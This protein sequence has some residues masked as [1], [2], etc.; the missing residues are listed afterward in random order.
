MKN[1]L[2][3]LMLFMPWI[4]VA[5]S[6]EKSRW[7]WGF[8]SGID[9]QTMG[10]ETFGQPDLEEPHVW[11]EGPRLGLSGGVLVK[12]TVL[13]WLEFLPGFGLSMINNFVQ[14]RPDGARAYRFYDMEIPLYFQ[15]IDA[16]KVDAPVKGCILAG[17]RFSWNLADNASDFLKINR[18]RFAA[19]LGLGVQLR[20][21]NWHIQPVF[22]Y[23]HGF[24]DLHF[25][26]QGKYDDLVGRVVRDKF[27]LKIQC[28]KIGK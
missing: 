1:C 6:N 16:R 26:D 19:D 14:Y 25:P 2:F 3:I 9:H 23:S 15:F 13:P 11:S 5:Q 12:K 4:L 18:E 20:I 7:N 28:W 21:R 8:F 10:I 24:N 17:P 27:S 22:I